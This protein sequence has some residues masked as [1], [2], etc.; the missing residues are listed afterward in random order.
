[1]SDLDFSHLSPAELEVALDEPALKPPDGVTPNFEHPVNENTVSLVSIFLCLVVGSIFLGCRIYIRFFKMRQQYIGDYLMIL[2]YPFWVMTAVGSLRR[3]FGA[4]GIFIHQWDFRGRDIAEYLKVIFMGMCFWA[5]STAMMKSAI[6]LEWIHIFS[7]AN[8][9][10]IFHRSCKILLIFTPLF[11][12]SLIIALNLSCTPYR[13]IWDKTLTG[14]C[15]DIKAIHIAATATNVILDI[16]ILI[17]PQ[18][19]IWKLKM[20]KAK[21]FGLSAV[22]AIGIFACIAAVGLFAAI[23]NWV[24]SNDLTYHYSA[25]ALWAIAES[26][27]GTMIFCAPVIPKLFRGLKLKWASTVS[28]WASSPIFHW[29]RRSARKSEDIWAPT[30]LGS[31]PR[32]YRHIDE[33]NSTDLGKFEAA[34]PTDQQYG[35]VC[36]TD[37]LVTESRD[38]DFVTDQRGKQSSW[39]SSVQENRV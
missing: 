1:M 24:E 4:T 27:C 9:R 7:A 33:S 31:D 17:L 25:V 3:I 11:Y 29:V 28:S 13:R 6:L 16:A 39:L 20:S 32:Q 5:A 12:A 38:A 36:T 22:F 35:I 18:R 14:T 19:I 21:K 23:I 26:T 15:I 37:I 30:G 8:T 10:T 34:R 2:A